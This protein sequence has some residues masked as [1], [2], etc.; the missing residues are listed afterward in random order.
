MI[1]QE[2]P[3]LIIL[4]VMMEDMDGWT[5]CQRLRHVCD[6]P[7]IMLTAKTEETDKI[8]GLGADCSIIG[9]LKT[10]LAIL[11]VA[12]VIV[13]GFGHRADVTVP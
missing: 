5:T 3:D 2:T 1:T 10:P 7:I 13:E 6:T 9:K 11:G 8:I 12:A 4:D